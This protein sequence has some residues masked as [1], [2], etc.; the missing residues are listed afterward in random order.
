M[1]S[2]DLICTLF[3][4]A[5][6]SGASVVDASLVALDPNVDHAL[7]TD[8]QVRS[9]PGKGVVLLDKSPVLVRKVRKLIMQKLNKWPFLNIKNSKE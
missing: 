7:L 2:S 6:A 9:V 8:F 3:F 5:N 1:Q 4:F